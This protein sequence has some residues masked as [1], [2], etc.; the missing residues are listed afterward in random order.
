MDPVIWEDDP[1]ELRSP[2]LVCAFAGWNDAA[3]AASAALEAVAASLE[4]EVVADRPGGVLR[5]PGQPADDPPGRGSDTPDRLA[6]EHLADGPRAH[7]GARS[8]AAQRDRA[9]CSLA[10]FRRGDPHGRR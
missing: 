3:S 4:A 6:G 7:G 10:H 8:G 9:Q 1:P 5:L 2:I